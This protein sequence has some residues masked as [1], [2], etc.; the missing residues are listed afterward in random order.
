MKYHKNS[1]IAQRKILTKV[2]EYQAVVPIIR[3]FLSLNSFP[4]IV[5]IFKEFL[6]F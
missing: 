1:K 5:G 4:F 6:T 3:I 2:A